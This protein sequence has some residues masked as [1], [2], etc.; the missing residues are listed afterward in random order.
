MNTLKQEWNVEYIIAGKEK[1]AGGVLIALEG[2]F[3]YIIHSQNSSMDGRYII[4]DLEI[5][6]VARFLLINIYAPND[7]APNFF[8]KLFEKIERMNIKNLIITGDWNLVNDYKLDTLNYKKH[9]NPKAAQTVYNYKEKLDLI[10]VWRYTNPQIKQFTWRQ[11]FYKKMAR[12]DYF[13][14]SETVLDIYANSEIKN[15]YRSDHSPV[16]LTL[17]ISKHKRGRGNWKLNNSLLLDLELKDK[18]EKE[19]ELI[20]STYACTPYHPEF[21]KNNY[22]E[23]NL[24]FMINIELLW[25]VLHA[26]LRSIIIP[27]S[28]K[29]KGFKITKKQH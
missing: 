12:L 4:L 1:N 14:I 21:I 7:D 26:Q 25:E 10:D 3:E 16:N 22:K 24:D 28:A 23:L 29:K 15:S 6:E 19:I 9:N 17:N 8:E 2:N 11:L 20:V 13:L 5:P 18:I 27:Y